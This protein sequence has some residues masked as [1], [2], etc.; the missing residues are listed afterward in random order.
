M[1]D[2]PD[3]C[4]LSDIIPRVVE[5][6]HPDRIVHFG[7]A[8]ADQL[9]GRVKVEIKDSARPPRSRDDYAISVD[10]AGMPAGVTVEEWV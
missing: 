5:V 7:N 9:F 3:P 4:A 6:V 2:H 1:A 8:R 10:T